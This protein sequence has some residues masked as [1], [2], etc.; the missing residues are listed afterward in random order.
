MTDTFETRGYFT[1]PEWCKYRG[2]SVPTY[3]KMR[4]ADL[5]PDETRVLNSVRIMIEADARWVEARRNPNIVESKQIASIA[6]Q[7]R[8]RA[9]RAAKRA[10]ASEKH[11]SRIPAGDLRRQRRHGRTS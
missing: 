8:N 2:Y 4:K 11:Y 5:A 6:E 7:R 10:V 9:K 3:Y 1:V